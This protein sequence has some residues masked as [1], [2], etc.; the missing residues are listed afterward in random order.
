M[1]TEII[2]GVKLAVAEDKQ[3]LYLIGI[4]LILKV[5]LATDEQTRKCSE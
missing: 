1:A 4:D 2:N 3:L 5:H